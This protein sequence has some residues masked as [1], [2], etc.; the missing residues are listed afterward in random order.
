[1]LISMLRSLRGLENQGFGCNAFKKSNELILYKSMVYIR[2]GF[3]SE[4]HFTLHEMAQ[5]N[6]IF[7]HK[8][9]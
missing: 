4:K 1:M 9:R 2:Y 6:K 3:G 8:S 7:V 5:C